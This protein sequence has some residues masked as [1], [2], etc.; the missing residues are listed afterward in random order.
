M[1]EHILLSP[2][3]LVVPLFWNMGI[4]RRNIDGLTKSVGVIVWEPD[5]NLI[6]HPPSPSSFYHFTPIDQKCGTTNSV[7]LTSIQIWK[8]KRIS[9]SLKPTQ[10]LYWHLSP[11]QWMLSTPITLYFFH[12]KWQSISHATHSHT[13]LK[14]EY[15]HMFYIVM[16]NHQPWPD[17]I[18]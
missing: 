18:Y 6:I 13:F 14:C 5:M 9:D 1:E 7:R 17:W 11:S 8:I 12:N 10:M 3:D 15:R 16:Q 4:E 2:T